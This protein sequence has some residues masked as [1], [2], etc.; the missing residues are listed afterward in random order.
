MPNRPVSSFPKGFLWGATTSAHQYEGGVHNQWT[1]W[2]LENAKALASQSSYQY[3]DL[4][5]WP[6]IKSAAKSPSNYISGRAVNGYELYQQ[7]IALARMMHLNTLRISIEWSRIQPEEGSWD[8]EAIN[9]YRQQ[10]I[11][12]K[13]SGIE[14]IVTLFHYTLPVWFAQKGGFEKRA[15]VRYFVEYVQHLLQE[16]GGGMRYIVTLNEPQTYVDM[17]YVQGKWPPQVVSKRRAH[18]V[19]QNLIYTHR[20]VA[21]II[22]AEN[23]RFKVGIAKNYTH[24]YPGDDAWLSEQ[25]AVVMRLKE[26]SYLLRQVAK[27]SDFIGINYK[28]SQRVYGYRV[29]NPDTHMSDVDAQMDPDTLKY[30]LQ[31]VHDSYHLPI[32]V[33]ASGIADYKDEYRKWWLAQSVIALQAAVQNGVTVLGF[34]VYALTDQFEWDRGF[35]PRYGLAEVDY[36]TMKRIPRPSAVWYAKVVKKLRG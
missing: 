32:I 18:S 9:H 5:V 23:R 13:K 14:P 19:L 11:A 36:T 34:V 6:H 31:E 21:E 27:H 35:W 24:I 3:D 29:H 2:E 7:D 10:F 26:N 25:S 20:K 15:N 22:H 33:T 30:V 17:S 28:G 12:M 16:I 8:A 1:V 4:A